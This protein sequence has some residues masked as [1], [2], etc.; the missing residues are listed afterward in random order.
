MNEFDFKPVDQEGA[1]TLSTI[2]EAD[3]FNEWMYRTI[4]PWCFGDILEIGSGLGNISTYFL[5]DQAHIFLSDIREVYC[6]E[7][8][9][10][11]AG[12]STLKGIQ[13]MDLADPDFDQKFGHLLNSFDTVFALNV[14]EHI[15]NDQQA[16]DNGYRLLKPG[17]HLVILVPAFQSL[18]NNFD[19]ELEHYRRYNRNKLA[20][21]FLN[22][23]FNICHSQYFNVAGMAGWVVSGKFQKHQIIPA[24]QMRLYNQL[25]PMFKLLDT[26]TL[27]SFGLSVIVVGEK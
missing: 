4:K 21:L 6:D 22:S 12:H 19:K 1:E 8:R 27:H 25:V 5:K 23:H 18:Y 17:G 14:L 15:F 11:F 2:A 3:R 10:K 9:T 13:A 26:L 7:L 16:I 24:G 20:S